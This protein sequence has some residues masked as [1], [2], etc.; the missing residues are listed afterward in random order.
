MAFAKS[1]A[2]LENIGTICDLLG[3]SGISAIISAYIS[4][5][6]IRSTIKEG[7]LGLSGSAS[8]IS[9]VASIMGMDTLASVSGLVGD[10]EA[11]RDAGEEDAGANEKKNAILGA[12]DIIDIAKDLADRR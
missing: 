7:D 5:R 11:M 8:I 10:I 6:D 12:K 9:N 2:S 1:D 4:G 3:I